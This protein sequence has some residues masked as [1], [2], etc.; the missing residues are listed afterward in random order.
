M[1]R[2]VLFDE[3]ASW[4][5]LLSPTPED[6]I[7]IIEDEA[8]K[9]NMIREEEEGFRTLEESLISFWLSGPNER[10]SQYDQSDEEPMSSGDSAMH[11]L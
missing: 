4:Y 3:L 7:P 9:P 6:F 2:D 1:S 10:L 11:S 5:S 8:I